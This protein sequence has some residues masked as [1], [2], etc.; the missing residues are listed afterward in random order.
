VTMTA[1]FT[2]PA[3]GASAEESLVAEGGA[4]SSSRAVPVLQPA[5]EALQRCS[6]LLSQL[7]PME[8]SV[9]YHRSFSIDEAL[10]QHK[11]LMRQHELQSSV[12]HNHLQVRK[13]QVD[14]AR[15]AAAEASALGQELTATTPPAMAKSVAERARE[16]T[17]A[18]KHGLR[19][20][21]SE[22]IKAA[23][24]TKI[25]EA[26]IEKSNQEMIVL[27]EAID[28][29]SSG[30]GP[31]VVGLPAPDGEKEKTVVQSERQFFYVSDCKVGG[32]GQRFCSYLLKRPNWRVYPS[33]KWFEDSQGQVSHCPLGRRGV[34]FTDESYFSRIVMHIKG[35][36]WLEDKRKLYEFVPDLMPP[37]FIIVDQQWVGD[38]P[39]P[40]APDVEPMPWFVKETDRNW[41]TSVQC[42]S[43]PEECMAL[44]KA[45]GTYVVQRHIPKPLLYY[46]GEKC[47]IK[48]YTLLVG[49]ADG[50]TWRLYTYK[51]GYLSISPKPWDPTDMS[52][53]GQVTI[54]RS[55]RIND[56]PHWDRV[57][58]KC[59]AG[60]AEVIRRAV[61]EGKLEGRPKIQFEIISSDYIVT[62]DFG[63]YLL[64]F[65][66]GPVLKD[67][68]DSPDVHDAGMIYGAL[69][70]VEPWAG[71]DIDNWDLAIECK[72]EPL[73]PSQLDMM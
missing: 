46:N 73:K 1:A 23:G 5:Q 25:M 27:R 9:K 60:V 7:P 56:W 58:P 57:Y 17:S 15:H 72:G 22:E 54:I 67:A 61:A 6:K 16:A 35:R 4:A 55:K 38:I 65:N 49:L 71:G 63:V 50:V 52:K 51:D 37:T 45:Q 12:G 68:E 43:K 70:I 64:E 44:T 41:G 69:H 30:G 11:S 48:F 66:T 36:I 18:L 53:E 59:K 34:D 24:K 28:D 14:F 19:A 20:G 10:E 26:E 40:E 32:H 2:P 33:E 29:V 31:D 47:H 21:Q 8:G 42:C 13:M 62:E 3:R 39:P